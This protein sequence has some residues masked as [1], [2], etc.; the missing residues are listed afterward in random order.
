MEV[1]LKIATSKEPVQVRI[2]GS[3]TFKSVQGLDNF[4]ATAKVAREWLKKQKPQPTGGT[5]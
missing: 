2:S 1:A 3:M 5:S 4:L